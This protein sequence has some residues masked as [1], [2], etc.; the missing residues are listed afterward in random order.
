M[1]EAA[2]LTPAEAWTYLRIHPKTVNRLAREK[3]IPALRVGRHWRFR[4][5]DLTQWTASQ[6]NSVRQPGE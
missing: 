4:E 3:A 1:T 2:L 6:V 5:V